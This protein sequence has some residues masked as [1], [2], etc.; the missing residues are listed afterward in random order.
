MGGKVYKMV[1][2]HERPKILGRELIKLSDSF[3]ELSYVQRF[4]KRHNYTKED[5]PKIVL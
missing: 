3:F 1:L 5:F 2:G 4:M